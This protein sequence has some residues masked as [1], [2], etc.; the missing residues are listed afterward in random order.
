[1]RKILWALS[2]LIVLALVIFF[3][4][5][6]KK[7]SVQVQTYAAPRYPAY[8][9]QQDKTLGDERL[10]EFTKKLVRTVE[11]ESPLGLVERGQKVLLEIN[12]YQDMRI[13]KAIIEAYK[14]REIA[15]DYI[16]DHEMVR[17]ALGI[18]PEEAVARGI[19]SGN[20][21]PSSG[22]RGKMS[23]SP[24]DGYI[25][26]LSAPG[27][28]P[29]QWKKDREELRRNSVTI[30]SG[31]ENESSTADALYHSAMRKYVMEMH[32]E[33]D[34]VF[35]GRPNRIYMQQ[36][37]GP[38]WRGY[39]SYETFNASQGV[40]A[41]RF[42]SDVWR[43]IIERTME[44][45]PWVAEARITDPQGTD[46]RFSLNQDQAELWSRGSYHLSKIYTYPFQ[47]TRLLYL[48]EGRKQLVVPEAEGVIA[49]TSNHNGFYPLIKAYVSKGMV[50]RVEGGG[51][52][53]DIWRS[54]LANEKVRNLHY[55]F[56]PRPGYFYVCEGVIG[57]NPKGFRYYEGIGNFG[58]TPRSGV[59]HWGFGVGN[60]APE[61]EEYARKNEVPNGHGFH[62]HQYFITYEMKT[63]GGA[64]PFK[65][66]DRGR[67]TALDD[68]EVKALA[69]RYGKA[70]ELL[71]EDWVPAMPGINMDG[72]F[73]RDYAGNPL[74]YVQR[75]ADE[76]RN[77]TYKYLR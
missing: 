39:F 20:P 21:R 31:G 56:L 7:E 48:T 51:K 10:R 42:P 70:E 17:Q 73:L 58:E 57:T 6:F 40:L 69:S 53:G 19:V 35:G 26:A 52:F 13:L 41:D 23:R 68:P 18:S 46:L 47:G 71:K 77:G 4:A 2:G 62:I 15:A 60:L 72:D 33:Y 76:I 12:K 61:V 24:R 75:E 11:G 1:M 50:E 43:L 8:L 44:I 5:P 34:A 54:V 3:F 30:L 14:E 37:V 28:L 27:L 38:K 59:F 29:A 65:I 32:P 16:Y 22:Q 9:Y 36:G 66:S 64:P 49:G 67:L 63:R 55:P 25:E 74:S 45:L